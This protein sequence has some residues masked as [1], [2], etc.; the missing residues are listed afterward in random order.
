M[1]VEVQIHGDAGAAALGE[2][3]IR[4]GVGYKVAPLDDGWWAFR[5]DEKDKRFL[6]P[7]GNYGVRYPASARR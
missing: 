3:L 5:V 7:A 4:A 6:P 1:L 2:T